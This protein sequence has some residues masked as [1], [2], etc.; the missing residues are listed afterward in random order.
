MKEDQKGS[1]SKLDNVQNLLVKLTVKVSAGKAWL[2]YEFT[3]SLNPGDKPND[4]QASKRYSLL[5]PVSTED[6]FKEN[7]KKN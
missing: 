5:Y 1:I 4:A 6:Q 2:L 7:S 3:F